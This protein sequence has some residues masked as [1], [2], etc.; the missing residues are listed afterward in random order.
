M[1]LTL[2]I[3]DSDDELEIPAEFRTPFTQRSP[4]GLSKASFAVG[5][6]NR[7]ASE[8]LD[9]TLGSEIED[10]SDDAINN[11]MDIDLLDKSDLTYGVKSEKPP[12]TTSSTSVMTTDVKPALTKKAKVLSTSLGA[13]PAKPKEQQ[14][15]NVDMPHNNLKPRAQYQNTNLPDQVQADHCWAK[16]F[17]PTMML[18]AGS[19]ESLWSIP[20]ATL[21][22]HIQIVFQA[23]YPE[24]NLAIVQNGAVFSLTVQ[25]LSEWQ[26]NFGSTAIAIIFKFLTSNNDCDPEVLAGLLLKNFAFIFEDMDKCEPD[27][28]FRSAFMLQLLGKAHLSAVNGHAIVPTLKTKDLASKRMASVIAFCA[29]VLERAVTL[30]SE[31]DI[32][33]ENI[34]ASTPSHSKL[35]IKLPKVLNK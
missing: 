4:V 25:R 32:K 31:G 27:G 14:S 29:T 30:I 28:A 17:L 2:T 3:D 21:L 13:T 1:A 11:K 22:T 10:F 34:L 12:R 35:N 26:S 24:L 18:W 19:Q 7:K 5:S 8:D 9:L 20:G 33:V 15:L 23:V 16:K 6:L